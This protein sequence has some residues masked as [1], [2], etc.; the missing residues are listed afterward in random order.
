MV[1]SHCGIM[2]IKRQRKYETVKVR[3]NLTYCIDAY[4]M[5]G[6]RYEFTCK[7]KELMTQWYPGNMTCKDIKEETQ[8]RL[9]K[10]ICIDVKTING[11]TYVRNHI[12]NYNL[13][14]VK[15]IVITTVQR[16]WNNG[17]RTKRGISGK[18]L[19]GS[20]LSLLLGYI[21]S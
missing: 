16:N 20:C 7:G 1:Q 8:Y 4:F 15:I 5:N 11:A 21:F 13:K 9:C 10:E 18:R 3:I 2:S 19:L 6:T 17:I 14:G 12:K